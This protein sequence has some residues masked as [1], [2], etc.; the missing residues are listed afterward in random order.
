[1]ATINVILE[2]VDVR[3]GDARRQRQTGIRSDPRCQRRQ[4]VADRQPVP[5][6]R[7]HAIGGD[8]RRQRRRHPGPGGRYWQGCALR[9]GRAT[10]ATTPVQDCFKTELTRFALFDADF[11][12]GVSVAEAPTSTE[13]RWPTTSSSRSGSGIESQVK[14]FSTTLPER[15]GQGA[16]CVL[17]LH[18]RIPDRSPASPLATGM[19]EL[20]S[21]RESV[22]TAPGPGEPPLVKTFRLGPV[23]A[24]RAIAGQRHH[25]ATAFGQAE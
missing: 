14:V 21:G 10:T 1:M 25:A 15:V 4:G 9:G 24:H 7:G 5:G 8:G 6:L 20:G 3:R 13:M 22:V 16:G 18:A 11:T 17:D 2:G 12:G 23:H 19:V